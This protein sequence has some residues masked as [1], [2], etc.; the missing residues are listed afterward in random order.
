MEAKAR[1]CPVG[2]AW[3]HRAAPALGLPVFVV[4]CGRV[5]LGRFDGRGFGAWPLVSPSG[6][7]AD[8]TRM[9]RAEE[10]SRTGGLGAGRVCVEAV[11]DARVSHGRRGGEAARRRGGEWA[12]DAFLRAP[13][14]GAPRLPEA[15]SLRKEERCAGHLGGRGGGVGTAGAAP[16]PLVDQPPGGQ[17]RSWNR[18]CSVFLMPD[19]LSVMLLASAGS[20]YGNDKKFCF[21]I[22]GCV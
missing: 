18:S 1:P 19:S 15:A 16:R 10:A 17:S 2:V 5:S 6:G 12:L 8:R 11:V 14:A 22:D 4:G 13:T 7:F 21:P 20:L 9:A 3:R